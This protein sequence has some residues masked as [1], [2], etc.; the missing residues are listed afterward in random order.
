MR[1]KN[2]VI[3]IGKILKIKKKKVYIITGLAR[4]LRVT[5]GKYQ[6]PEINFFSLSC[7]ASEAICDVVQ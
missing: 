2:K 4:L 3:M 7:T 6:T 5:S 1:E